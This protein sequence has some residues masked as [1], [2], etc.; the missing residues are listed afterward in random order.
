MTKQKLLGVSAS[1]YHP[2][3]EM[4]LLPAKS[5]SGLMAFVRHRWTRGEK[6]IRGIVQ[7][8]NSTRKKKK[9]VFRYVLDLC[10]HLLYVHVLYQCA[11]P[12]S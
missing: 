4:Y 2:E 8:P 7:F 9:V 3:V 5:R 12:I 10:L 6:R 11:I 1:K